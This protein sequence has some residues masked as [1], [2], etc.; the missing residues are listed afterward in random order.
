[1]SDL[2]ELLDRAANLIAIA[3]GVYGVYLIYENRDK[4]LR[5]GQR[6]RGTLTDRLHLSDSLTQE[7]TGGGIESQASLGS[8]TLVGAAQGRSNASGV[9]SVSYPKKLSAVEEIVWWVWR[10]R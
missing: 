4:L 6:V 9:L 7:L 10:V 3:E 1:M 2:W 5:R 8:G